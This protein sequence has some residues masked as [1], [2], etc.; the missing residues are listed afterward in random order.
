ME[1]LCIIR[2]RSECGRYLVAGEDIKTDE[3]IYHEK[4]FAFVPVCNDYRQRAISHHCQNCA[5]T[6]CIPFPCYECARA[7]YCSPQCS[8]E[9]QSIH[10]FECVGY[11]KNLWTKIGIAH[12]AMRTL[13]VGVPSLMEKIKQLKPQNV[14]SVWHDMFS[15]ADS[16]FTYGHVLS[17]V[18]HF[19]DSPMPVDSVDCLRYAL[20]AK[21]LT[22]YLFE[23]TSFYKKLISANTPGIMDKNDWHF[24]VASIL[25]RHMGQLVSNGHAISDMEVMQ[26]SDYGESYICEKESRL[27]GYL[28]QC[29]S[30][31]RVFTAIFP[32][33]SLLNHS[34]D[35]NIRNSFDGQS[36]TIYATRSIAENEQVFNCYGPHYKLMHKDERQFALKQQYRFICKCDKCSANDRTFYQYYRYVCPNDWCNR[37]IPMDDY[38]RHQWWLHLDNERMSMQIASKIKCQRCNQTS[39]LNPDTLATFSIQHQ[40]FP[41]DVSGKRH[42]EHVKTLLS[43]YFAVSKC[44]AKDHELKQWMAQQILSYKICGKIY[45]NGQLIWLWVILI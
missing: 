16:D 2:K 18:T 9:H 22:I 1:F 29:L 25:M 27:K 17:L 37:P 5:R 28:Y 40:M 19:T 34:C 39:I 6:N 10:E 3:L 24:M 32:K 13:L 42:T 45:K 33:I 12:L 38:E 43:Y 8:I 23:H 4:A 21:M 26:P 14:S 20:T 35:P 15:I 11:Q 31:T 36:L 30:S 7:T 44:L 41:R